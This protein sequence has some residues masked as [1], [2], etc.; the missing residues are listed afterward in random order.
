MSYSDLGMQGGPVQQLKAR[1][2]PLD[3]FNDVFARR[4]AGGGGTM[5]PPMRDKLLVDRVFAEYTRL[6]QTPAPV[7]ART[8]SWSTST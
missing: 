2:N 8:S 6:K 1:T 4:R 5:P 3:A 7:G